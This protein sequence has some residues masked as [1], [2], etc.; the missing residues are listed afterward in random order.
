MAD[1][2]RMQQECLNLAGI[3]VAIDGV[4]GPELRFGL[5]AYV[6]TGG[7]RLGQVFKGLGEEGL[8][9]VAS[10]TDLLST[11]T[12]RA[13]RWYLA[14]RA[15]EVGG[16]NAGPWVRW[17][18]EGG[19]G[20]WCAGFAACTCLRDAERA[21]N[22]SRSKVGLPQTKI[23]ARYRSPWCPTLLGRAMASGQLVTNPRNVQPGFLALLLK[24]GTSHHVGIVEFVDVA[25]GLVLT[26]EGNA[27]DSTDTGTR[28]RV[29]RHIRRAGAG[30]GFI[31]IDKEA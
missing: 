7:E 11:I 2:I 28:D 20:A 19:K 4:D 8:W 3:P 21:L 23:A 24:D 27:P 6:A 29:A 15:R 12:L 13:A 17:F 16:E 1:D 9:L 30:L 5:D 22:L 18:L 10:A 31:D 25:A 26:I 14:M